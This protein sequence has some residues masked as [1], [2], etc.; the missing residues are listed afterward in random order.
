MPATWPT[1]D[2]KTLYIYIH[3]TDRSLFK[4]SSGKK[5]F[6]WSIRRKMFQERRNVRVV[7]YL[8]KEH[9][10][11][12]FQLFHVLNS[13]EIRAPLLPPSPLLA[14]QALN[15]L[16]YVQWPFIFQSFLFETQLR[17]SKTNLA[18]LREGLDLEC[19]YNISPMLIMQYKCEH[20]L[21][22]NTKNITD[23]LVA[24]LVGHPVHNLENAEWPSVE[25]A[26]KKA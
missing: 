6:Y 11:L 25:I 12:A 10:C 1:D 3:C 17:S 13:S 4:V 19:K 9:W 18:L 8:V 26:R 2:S 7:Y 15:D 22:Q 24:D 23:S 21:H 16:L 20:V 5:Q 14:P